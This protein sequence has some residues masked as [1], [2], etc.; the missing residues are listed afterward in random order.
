MSSLLTAQSNTYSEW[1]Q[2]SKMS[3]PYYVRRAE[4]FMNN[5]LDKRISLSQLVAASGVSERTLQAGFQRYLGTTPLRKLKA[6][7][8]QAVHGVLLETNDEKV[9]VT[10][11]A[12]SFGFYQFGRFSA[13]YKDMF[14]VLPSKTLKVR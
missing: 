14:G 1:L 10:E 5:H 2:P 8:L 11:I 12:A 4:R 3:V 6:L 13:D 7:R 9:R